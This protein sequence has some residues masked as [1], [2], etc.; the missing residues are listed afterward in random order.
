VAPGNFVAALPVAFTFPFLAAFR[1]FVIVAPPLF[2]AFAFAAIFFALALRLLANAIL[3]APPVGTIGMQQTFSAIFLA[4]APAAGTIPWFFTPL[5]FANAFLIAPWSGVGALP[6]LFTFVIL[7]C[8]VQD[9][10]FCWFLV[11]T[12]CSCSTKTVGFPRIVYVEVVAKAH[13]VRILH[14]PLTVADSEIGIVIK[15]VFVRAEIG[16]SMRSNKCRTFFQSTRTIQ[17]IMGVVAWA[18]QLCLVGI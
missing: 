11:V 17:F 1:G 3:V 13:L 12:W 15:Y 10:R 18:A 2:A 5:F 9:R 8:A 7:G 4:V 14:S 16:T 6:M